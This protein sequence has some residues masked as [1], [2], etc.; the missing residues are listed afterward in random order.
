M[1]GE[2][3][4]DISRSKEP[5]SRPAPAG[6]YETREHSR[7]S[8]DEDGRALATAEQMEATRIGKRPHGRAQVLGGIDCWRIMRSLSGLQS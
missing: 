8:V 1:F 5:E 7:L 6:T 4:A 3:I 2:D